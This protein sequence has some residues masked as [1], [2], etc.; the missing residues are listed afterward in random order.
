LLVAKEYLGNC[1]FFE[2]S[3]KNN[4][5]VNEAFDELVRQVVKRRNRVNSQRRD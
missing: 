1:P 2:T 3:A 5:S 4:I